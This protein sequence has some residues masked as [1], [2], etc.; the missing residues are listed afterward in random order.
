VRYSTSAPGV[1][2]FVLLAA[3]GELATD[4]FDEP[5]LV[6]G[7]SDTSGVLEGSPDALGV[8][9]LVNEASLQTL[10]DDVGL[11]ATAAANIVEHRAG[12]DATD[13]TVDDDP[14]DDLAE[15]DAVAYVGPAAFSV[16][17]D[18]ARSNGYVTQTEVDFE[19]AAWRMP[20]DT[21]PTASYSVSGGI[22]TDLVTGLQW[23]QSFGGPSYWGETYCSQLWLDGTGWRLPTRIELESLVDYGTFYPAINTSVFPGTPTGVFWSSTP[24]GAKD[25]AWAVR[26]YFGTTQTTYYGPYQ[27]APST[28][29]YIRCVRSQHVGTTGTIG[30][31]AGRYVTSTDTVRDTATG[32]TWQRSASTGLTK[33]AAASYCGGLSLAGATTWRT[34]SVKELQSLVDVRAINPAI[35]HV[36][37]PDTPPGE[38]YYSST[39]WF[40]DASEQWSVE[41]GRGVN[42]HTAV[43]GDYGVRCVH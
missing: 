41:S 1:L 30:A 9:G 21:P 31:P 36:A 34:P 26:F 39:P 4:G 3:C 12:S 24:T 10:D 28:T 43:A 29:G 33:A 6:D 14:F 20:S 27:N 13:G 38:L 7:K 8:L 18:Y 5:F 23:Q 2:T 35:D 16:L 37:F 42:W 32:L 25:T 22:V 11:A 15:L 40:N 19:W 17:L